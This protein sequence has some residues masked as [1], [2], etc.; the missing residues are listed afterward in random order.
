MI[1]PATTR[2]TLFLCAAAL[3]FISP[4]FLYQYAGQV[5]DMYNA[6]QTGHTLQELAQKAVAQCSGEVYKPA[7][8]DE[9]LPA[10]MDTGLSMEDTF[11]VTRY[12]QQLDPSYWYC[13]VLGHRLSERETAKDPQQWVGVIGRCPSGVCSNG[14]IHGAFQERFRKSEMTPEEAYALIPELQH[15]CES[16][17]TKTFTGL[18]QG[19]CYHA[20]GHLTMY[21]TGADVSH[22]LRMCEELAYKDDGR[23]FRRLCYD[24]LFMQ[25]YQPLEPE[26]FGLVANIAPK[27]QMA[28]KA[29]CDTYSGEVRS[30]CRSESW[31]LFDA[32]IHTPEG[33][34]S[35]CDKET[36]VDSRRT[37][38][39]GL[40]YV[41]T[42]S[43]D[44][45]ARKVAA[46]C[47]AL[48]E[49]VQGLCF[50][51]AASR[52]I[53]TDYALA[54]KA[55]AICESAGDMRERCFEEL[56]FYSNYN[57]HRDSLEQQTF[58]YALPIPWAARC[59][60]K[61]GEQTLH[62]QDAV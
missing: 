51:N 28:A 46:F 48:P 44:F 32:E 19:S 22:A 40:M 27:T 54:D 61:E 58:C 50:G 8:Y 41:I 36:N 10:F 60:E 42:P 5:R 62:P 21:M 7:C 39:S 37:C 43:F 20:L 18:E 49:R 23:D 26:D 29:F 14:C 16:S 13:H 11:R 30:S 12:V 53:E 25:I 33:L 17:A 15:V 31:P 59:G 24:G 52:T 1:T 57:F 45:D 35:F 6:Y 4:V 47:E 34:V 56:L 38:Y 9:V 55:V 2:T 3:V